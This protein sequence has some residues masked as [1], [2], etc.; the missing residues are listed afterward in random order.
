MIKLVYITGDIHGEYKRFE[1]K[2]LKK[3]NENDC[4]IVCG[5]F[6]FIW[7]NS[8]K[9]KQILKKICDKKYK[10]LFV[11]GTHENF[12]LLEQYPV[13]EL[14]GGRARKIGG[15][16]YHLLR[17]E[18]YTIED[19]TYFTFG[20]GES[21]DRD[22]RKENGTWWVQEQPTMIEMQYAVEQLDKIERT[23]DYVITH[24]PP[25]TD[26]ALLERKHTVNPLATFFDELSQN[27]T[28]K[29]WYFGCLHKNKKV[30]HS[31]CLFTDIVKIT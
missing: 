2:K 19:K 21:T 20:G 24:Q 1:N 26:M 27:I 29:K 31:Q 7:N 18:I 6:G 9:E 10:T 14:Y 11:D 30:R 17:G 28:Y 15:N 3:L 4:L 16:L 5:D 8:D 12:A 22:L 13:V 23:V 25:M